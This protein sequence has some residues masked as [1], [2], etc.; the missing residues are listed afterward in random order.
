MR[1]KLIFGDSL[2][3]LNHSN[4]AVERNCDD[5]C[6]TLSYFSLNTDENSF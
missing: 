6:P 4:E 2:L 3:F 5:A 1:H